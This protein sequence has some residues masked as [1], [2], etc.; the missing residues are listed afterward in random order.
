[1][2]YPSE[3]VVAWCQNIENLREAMF[4]LG[5]AG[6]DGWCQC[7]IGEAIAAFCPPD[8]QAQLCSGLFWSVWID[9]VMHSVCEES[10]YKKQFRPTYRFPRLHS[11]F[12][13]ED[14]PD[15]SPAFLLTCA[16]PQWVYAKPDERLLF[17]DK[18]AFC[19]EVSAWL[20]STEQAHLCQAAEA[21][22]RSDLSQ[23]F[24]NDIE[25]GFFTPG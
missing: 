11:H 1:M 16:D 22:F 12:F 2:R 14:A 25:F 17:E 6:E 3:A 9:Q 7:Q 19:G 23:R 15:A 5:K 10:F 13:S 18:R 8:K 24:P 4:R 20:Q 21:K